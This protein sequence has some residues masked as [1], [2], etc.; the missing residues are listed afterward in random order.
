VQCRRRGRIIRARLRAPL[1]RPALSV[2]LLGFG[3]VG[4]HVYRLLSDRQTIAE[5]AGGPLTV[6]RIAVADL[7][8]DREMKVPGD[9]LTADA[10]AV[11]GASDVDIVVEVMGGRDQAGRLVRQAL[12]AGKPVV[13]ANKQ[14]MAE[15][16]GDLLAVAARSGVDLC[17]EG[18]VGA[19]IPL[20]KPIRESLAAADLRAVT[21][22]LNG[23]T[24][25][26]LTRMASEGYSY[27]DALA[28]AQRR[29]FAEA[30][31][32]EDV[33]GRDSAAKLAI[34]ASAA[35]NVTLRG[36]DVFREGIE[37][38]T[39]KDLAYA[40][41]FGFAVKLLGIA[42]GAGGMIEARVHPALLPLDHPLANVAD[43]FN[44]V[45][46]ESED[47]GPVIFTGRGAGGPPT[48]AAV[49]GDV[50]DVARNL[51]LGVS[52]RSRPAARRAARIRPMEDVVLPYYLSL[53]LTDR[54]GVFARVA[55]IFGEEG[56]SIASI[57]QK[58][59]GEVADAVFV[60]HDAAERAVRRVVE[61]LQSLEVVKAVTNRV[62]VEAKV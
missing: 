61:R 58:S 52:G 49:V 37:R 3:T 6:R 22:I 43:E 24:N 48:A 47:L 59:R 28:E 39:R 5:R 55:A 45:Q 36:S 46:V 21:G 44:A 10:A 31:P 57:V 41:E 60:T 40:R 34:L 7:E 23:T 18:S 51:R 13:T 29:G 16:G 20:I 9:L 19:G 17:F 11:V 2:G 26:I 62:R 14:L 8:K 12:E 53:Q 32:A 15:D 42:R 30:D 50:I 1:V 38:I 56:V 25:Y 33:D 35:F 4:A 27:A 54:P